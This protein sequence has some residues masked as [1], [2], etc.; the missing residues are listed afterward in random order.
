M[1]RKKSQGS[2]GGPKEMVIGG[3]TNVQHIGHMGFDMKKGFEVFPLLKSS[4]TYRNVTMLLAS[5]FSFCSKPTSFH[6]LHLF[7]LFH[8]YYHDAVKKFATRMDGLVWRSQRNFEIHGRER[9]NQKGGP[10]SLSNG[11]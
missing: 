11:I 9:N 6:P 10:N 3:P 4:L 2:K 8:T 7:I 5:F 1:S